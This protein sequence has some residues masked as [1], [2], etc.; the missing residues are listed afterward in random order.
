MCLWCRDLRIG[1]AAGNV[2][3]G[4][5]RPVLQAERRRQRNVERRR[6]DVGRIPAQTDRDVR[7]RDVDNLDSPARRANDWRRTLRQRAAGGV[8]TDDVVK[9][10]R[11]LTQAQ[12]RKD[13]VGRVESE[14]VAAGWRA[15]RQLKVETG[16]AR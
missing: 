3:G 11:V 5:R 1:A 9:V 13:K 16:G 12:R 14:V 4:A 6:W 7:R 8:E 15:V 10:G 2:A